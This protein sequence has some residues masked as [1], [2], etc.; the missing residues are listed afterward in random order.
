[1][2]SMPVVNRISLSKP[3][4]KPACGTDPYFRSSRY[5]QYAACEARH[6][7]TTP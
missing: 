3:S 6:S 4:P 7:L 1:M 5:H 2:F